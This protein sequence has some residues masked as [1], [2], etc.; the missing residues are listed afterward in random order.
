MQETIIKTRITPKKLTDKIVSRERLLSKFRDNSGK[1]MI[2]VT[3]PAGY[4]KTTSVLDYLNSE[5]KPYAWFHVS[6]DIESFYGFINYFIH[7]LRVLKTDFGEKTLELVSSLVQSNL[8]S[9]DEAGSIN[10]VMGTFV[11][12][13]VSDFTDETYMVLD[14]LH[15]IPEGSW[16]NAAINSLIGN[17]PANLHI[18]ITSRSEPGFNIAKLKAKRNLLIID[19]DDLNFTL[20]ETEKLVTDIY[21]LLYDKDDISKLDKTIDGWV[22]GLH[23]ILQ[24]YG[25]DFKK[26]I[27][28]GH[29]RADENIFDYFAEDIFN[30]IDPAQ[31]DF[32][33]FTSMLDSFTT[34]M[35]DKIL[36]I[37]GSKT[38]L[39]E[40]KRKNLFI[41]STIIKGIKSETDDLYSYHNLFRQ[42]LNSKLSDSKTAIEIS[43]FAEKIFRYYLETGDNTSAIEYSLKAKNYEKASELLTREYESVFGMGRYEQLWK[44]IEQFP[45]DHLEANSELLFIKGKLLRFF[46]NDLEKASEHFKKIISNTASETKLHVFASSELS[47]ILQ[48]TG[49]PEEALN[50]FKKLYQIETPPGL[51][52][53]IIISLARSYY[54]LGAKYYDDIIKLLDECIFIAEENELEQAITDIYGLY[55]RIYL[56]K[57]DFIKSQHYFESTAKRE[58]NIY[59]KFQTIN[60]LVLSFGWSGQ[61]L[62]A[63]EYYDEAAKIFGQFKGPVFERD[64]IRLTALLAFEAGDYESAIMHFTELVNLDKKNEFNSY[65]TLHYLFICEA[66]ILMNENEKAKAYLELAEIA[67]DPE[68]EYLNVEMN[69]HRAIVEKM[70]NVNSSIEKILLETLKS[71]ENSSLYST[72]Q[73]QFHLADYYF[74]NGL[75]STSL[76]YL[77][78]CLKTASEKQYNSFVVQHFMQM[79]YLFDFAISN[80]IHKQYIS[81]IYN[82][83]VERNSITWLSQE[84]I[85]RIKKESVMLWDIQLNTFGGTELFVRGNPVPDEK[86]IRKKSKLLLIYLLVN[87]GIKIN[88]DKVLGLFFNELSASS[89]ENVFHQA[90]TNIR[91]ALKPE[92]RLPSHAE[93]IYKKAK[94]AKNNEAPVE[95]SP[96][97]LIYEDKILYMSGEFVYKTDVLEFNRLCSIVKSPET[98]E[99]RKI[100]SAKTAV[101][102]YKGEFLPGYYD[103]WIEEMRTVL[104]HK[105]IEICEILID[106]FHKRKNFD[107][108][109]TYSEKL[110]QVDKL[111]EEASLALIEAYTAI[112]NNNM[113]KKKFSQLLKNYEDE[114]GEK[115]SKKIMEQVHAILNKD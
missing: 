11:N 5:K 80:N 28:G 66:N 98:D 43:S 21:S 53:K 59:K 29:K 37:T 34:A 99:N 17:F 84:C 23:L 52:S 30:Q 97:Y 31:Q 82:I 41:E 27:S 40:L 57:G 9:I 71:Y 50:I 101:D 75:Y 107:E 103:E 47:E 63:K 88:K 16:L 85:S 111:H 74:K 1:N 6:S 24:A 69:S 70:K 92:Q 76:Q 67:K 46:K 102:L 15:N 89:A 39:S 19:S 22:T 104:E 79:R 108:L 33:L 18:I 7:A 68:D 87:Q 35:C 91:S 38:I 25:E 51:K 61:Y 42:F 4:G 81:K 77:D 72:T 8:L 55:G 26:V 45:K 10:S 100:E 62:K 96:S 54:R 78:S 115:P 86:W 114:Y 32:L 110:L 90:I 2:F 14:D 73:I 93:K 20:D 105:Y 83:V 95:I 113:A 49:K 48:V 109:I 106:L 58:T 44:W 56:N 65:L 112:G 64:F 13:F 94:P 60:N 12:D 3:G 36:G